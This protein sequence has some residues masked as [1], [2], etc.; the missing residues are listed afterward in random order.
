MKVRIEEVPDLSLGLK[1]M[2]A[3]SSTL[4]SVQSI[5]SVLGLFPIP[6]VD[7]ISPVLASG[8]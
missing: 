7:Y 8:W 3:M 1:T 4:A 2:I 5:P 6:G